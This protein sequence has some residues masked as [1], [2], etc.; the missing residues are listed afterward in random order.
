MSHSARPA[1][2]RQW[3]NDAA[4]IG[5]CGGLRANR[6]S[7][8]QRTQAIEGAGVPAEDRCLRLGPE[9]SGQRTRHGMPVA[10]AAPERA[11]RPVAA[12]DEALGS[13]ELEQS[14]DVGPEIGGGDILAA[15]V[16][17]PES[18]QKTCGWL[19]TSLR[20][21]FQA[22][23]PPPAISGFAPWSTMR[24]RSGCFSRSRGISGRWRGFAS[25]SKRR[26]SST[27]AR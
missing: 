18:L 7:G 4:M 23:R 17:S 13:E 21:R 3:Y 26:P 24:A 1:S 10:V 27:R 6:R 14:L 25:A 20:S 5:D 22:A 11:D 8:S 16:T 2:T 9:R 12:E 19:A 15:S